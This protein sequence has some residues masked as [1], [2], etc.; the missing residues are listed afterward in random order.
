MI[1][2]YE[3]IIKRADTQIVSALFIMRFTFVYNAKYISLANMI[4][5]IVI[6]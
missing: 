2:E 6:E 1:I 4:M 5:I 3:R